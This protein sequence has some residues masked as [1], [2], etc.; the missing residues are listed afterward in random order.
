MEEGTKKSVRTAF[1]DKDK[2]RICSAFDAIDKDQTTHHLSTTTKYQ[3][4]IEKLHS[5]GLYLNSTKYSVRNVIDKRRTDQQRSQ[6]QQEEQQTNEFISLT[7]RGRPNYSKLVESHVV[8]LIAQR[9][10]N[11]YSFAASNLPQLVSVLLLRVF[12]SQ[13][14]FGLTFLLHSDNRFSAPFIPFSDNN[15]RM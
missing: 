7:K 8:S 6:Q 14:Q 4:A 12:L 3:K 5:Q 9:Q 2:R 11:N 1:E 10:E 13:L 15:Q